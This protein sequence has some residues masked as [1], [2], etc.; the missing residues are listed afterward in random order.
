[1]KK[2]KKK[3]KNKREEQQTYFNSYLFKFLLHTIE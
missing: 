3:R 2:K 1:M